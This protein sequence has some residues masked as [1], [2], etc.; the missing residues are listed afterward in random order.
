MESSEIEWGVLDLNSDAGL[1]IGAF[2][3]YFET[4]KFRYVDIA[5]KDDG[6]VAISLT[7]STDADFYRIRVDYVP[8]DRNVFEYQLFT[9]TT[10]SSQ[11]RVSLNPKLHTSK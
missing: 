1:K 7:Y 10:C 9:P 8:I 11:L 2:D 5:C 4:V 6:N 3:P